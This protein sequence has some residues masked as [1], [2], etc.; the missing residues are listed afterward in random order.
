[1]WLATSNDEKATVSGYYFHHQK[2]RTPNP[3]AN[4][5]AMQDKFLEKCEAVT[6]VA[7][8]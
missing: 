6:G 8:E 3:L 5:E 4:D 7:F 1:V 2:Q